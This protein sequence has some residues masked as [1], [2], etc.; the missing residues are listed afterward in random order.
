M[1]RLS[2]CSSGCDNYV[3]K[4]AMSYKYLH[5]CMMVCVT[6]VTAGRDH[7]TGRQ[8]DR[9]GWV[10]LLQV[11]TGLSLRRTGSSSASTVME[12]F[13]QWW[14]CY[15]VVVQILSMSPVVL[16]E[17]VLVV[18]AI[19]MMYM[20]HIDSRLQA[21][22]FFSINSRLQATIFFFLSNPCSL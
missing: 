13:G 4:S 21:A 6:V 5:S 1:D 18:I 20:C 10:S 9:Q 14:C 15:L 3:H 7:L 19:T 22:T 16:I 12:I 8:S 11:S 17:R 2:I